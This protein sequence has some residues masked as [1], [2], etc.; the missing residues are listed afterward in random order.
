MRTKTTA[1]ASSR[2]NGAPKGRFKK[3]DSKPHGSGRKR[4]TPNRRGTLK[5]AVIAAA[6]SVGERRSAETGKYEPGDGGLVGYM[7]HLA[8]HN[9]PVFGRLLARVLP[10][11]KPAAKPERS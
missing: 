7:V 2:P 4:G 5:E 1:R 9:E 6:N 3:G 11:V 8:L 10:R